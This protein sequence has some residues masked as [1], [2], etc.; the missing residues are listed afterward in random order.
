MRVAAVVLLAACGRIGFDDQA[1]IDAAPPDPPALVQQG[2]ASD[3]N[4]NA[5]AVTGLSPVR[6]G[7]LLVAAVVAFGDST[8]TSVRDD[9]GDTFVS[10][11]ANATSASI[12][13]TTSIYYATTIGGATT[14]D[15][16]FDKAEG[17]EV[18]LLD[19]SGV[20]TLGSVNATNAM[21]ANDMYLG[22]AIT[23]TV[24]NEVVVTHVQ[25]DTNAITDV[26]APFV[27]LPTLFGDD[28]A[29]AITT[30]VG[31]YAATWTTVGGNGNGEASITS[32]RP[33]SPRLAP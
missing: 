22:P 20:D 21:S 24:A 30:T 26:S 27:M 3:Q 16:R 33:T 6:E 8:T 13:G 28:A 19:F 31:S 23:T 11:G 17:G 2:S 25:I 5:L 7:D 10:S 18:W 12:S 14:L 32:F 9:V 15:V 29:Y 4:G 1:A